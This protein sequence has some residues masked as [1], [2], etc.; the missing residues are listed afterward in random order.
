MSDNVSKAGERGLEGVV[1]MPISR[2][3]ALR[4]AYEIIARAE[5]GRLELAEWESQRGIYWGEEA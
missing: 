4:I 2:G 5:R 3:E 1:G